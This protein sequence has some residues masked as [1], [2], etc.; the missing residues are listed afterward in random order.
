MDSHVRN[1]FGAVRPYVYGPHSILEF[2]ETSLGGEVLSRHEQGGSAIHVEVKIDDSVLVLEL[3][4]PPHESGFPGSIYVYVKD[5]DVAVLKAKECEV[6]V[7]ASPEDK[8]YEERQAGIRDAYGNVWWIA[9]Y[10][11]DVNV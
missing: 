8:P 4:D 6:H 3:C 9:T 10:K 5:V 7:F 2:V 1:G 11:P